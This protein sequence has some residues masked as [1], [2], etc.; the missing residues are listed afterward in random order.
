[1][2]ECSLV[3]VSKDGRVRNYFFSKYTSRVYVP[4]TYS[5][6]DCDCLKLTNFFIEI[7]L[8]TTYKK[9]NVIRTG[10]DTGNTDS[11]PSFNHWLK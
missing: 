8:F 10:L 3:T 1:M 11:L 6:R 9:R 2:N 5:N 4:F 7:H